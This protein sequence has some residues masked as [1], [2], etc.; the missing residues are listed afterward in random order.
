MGGGCS[1]PRHFSYPINLYR[2]HELARPH[3]DDPARGLTSCLVSA[4]AGYRL[5]VREGPLWPSDA[6]SGRD[7]HE[8]VTSLLTDRLVERPPRDR[9]V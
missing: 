5:G 4:K 6:T 7:A 3:R 1:V 9:P 8:T 2:G